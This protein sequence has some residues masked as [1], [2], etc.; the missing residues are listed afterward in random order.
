MADLISYFK[1]GEEEIRALVARSVLNT[2]DNLLIEFSAPLTLATNTGRANQAMFNAL[3]AGPV[4]YLVGQDNP[5]ERANFL[6][7]LETAYL[8]LSRSREA[9]LVAEALQEMNPESALL[10]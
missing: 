4:P 5:E 1:I 10:Q 2:D 9:K 7:S 3:T 8:R 6:A